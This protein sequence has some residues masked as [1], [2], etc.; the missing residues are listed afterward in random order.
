MVLGNRR[1]LMS[2]LKQ[3]KKLEEIIKNEEIPTT[4]DSLIQLPD[5]DL[6]NWDD[7]V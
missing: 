6:N 7:P 3:H 2:T 4:F 1:Q 5:D